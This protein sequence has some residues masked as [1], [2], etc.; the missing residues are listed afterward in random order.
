VKA[1]VDRQID[2][3]WKAPDPDPETL[4]RHLFFEGEPG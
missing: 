3:A 2:E 4:E 1:D